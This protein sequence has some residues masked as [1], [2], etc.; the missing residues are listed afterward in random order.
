MADE[1]ALEGVY[2]HSDEVVS[3]E[4]EGETI[5]VPLTSGIGDME[6]ELYTLNGTGRAVWSRLDG[7][8]SL[9][10]I[11][12]ELRKEFEAPAGAIENDVKGLAAELLKR[13]MVVRKA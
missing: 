2:A 6:D 11:A 12:A 13:R 1:I 5:I 7:V 4:I 8:K 3:R 9:A 10:E